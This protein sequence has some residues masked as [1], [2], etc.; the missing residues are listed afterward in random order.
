MYKIFQF[1]YIIELLNSFVVFLLLYNLCLRNNKLSKVFLYVV[2]YTLIH[3]KFIN[4]NVEK[5]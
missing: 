1:I 4:E 2:K 5:M 3:L